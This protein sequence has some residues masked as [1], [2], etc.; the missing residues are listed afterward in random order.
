MKTLFLLLFLAAPSAFAN[1]PAELLGTYTGC[2]ISSAFGSVQAVFHLTELQTDIKGGR[3]ITG[4]FAWRTA[5]GGIYFPEVVAD[6]NRLFMRTE[7]K[8]LRE[9]GLIINTLDIAVNADRSLTGKYRTNSMQGD[10]RLLG[11]DWTAKKIADG[12]EIPA[13]KCH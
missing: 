12:A 9:F 3:Q 8:P 10:G 2:G 4:S 1:V 11:G 6:G 13:L 7:I 5:A